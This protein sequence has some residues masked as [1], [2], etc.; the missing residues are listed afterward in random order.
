MVEPPFSTAFSATTVEFI[1]EIAPHHVL[2]TFAF[3]INVFE[4]DFVFLNCPVTDRVSAWLFQLWF[5]V[6][7]LFVFR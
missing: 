5:H 7:I 2:I 6:L 1:G 4:D 3:L